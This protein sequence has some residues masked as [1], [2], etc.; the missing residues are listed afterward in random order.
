MN[1]T[2]IIKNNNLPPTDSRVVVA[3]SGGV[4]SSVTAAILKKIGY[5]VIGVTMKL[6]QS[7]KKANSKTC[8]SGVDIA[9]ARNVCKKLGI[10]HYIIDLE[11]RFKKSVVQNFVN[12]YKNGETPIPCIRCNQTVKFTDLIN[13]TKKVNGA[14]LATGHYIKR[15]E[16]KN[17]INL[18]Q[19]NDE[20]KDQSYFLFATTQDQLKILRFPLGYFSKS[21][22]RELAQAFELSVAD[23][24]ESQDIC[25]IPDGDYKEF[26]KQKKLVKK[27]KGFIESFDGKILGE[28]E[29]I[30]N[31]TIGQRKGIGIGG[32]SGKPKSSPYY[33]IEIDK[34]NN[35][36]IVGPREKLATY[37]IYV[38]EVNFISMK[39]PDK[40]FEAFVKV[41]SRRNLISANIKSTK[42]SKVATIELKKPE[43]GIAPG[44]A[45]VFYSNKKK[46]IGGGW[47]F[48]GEKINS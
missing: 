24:R 11:E 15:I 27:K 7:K 12:S 48:S 38:K 31:Y 32:L 21:Q 23:K 16:N 5:E 46:I 43:F 19:A 22:I 1:Y 28:H 20:K 33:V 17:G 26:L 45:C 44:Q 18:Y 4:D 29:G 36:I 2:E 35:K 25:F 8:C 30:F 6:H 10:R 3:M 42:D 14:I 37:L 13:F 40:P 34:K 41:R 39:I 47:I 9:D